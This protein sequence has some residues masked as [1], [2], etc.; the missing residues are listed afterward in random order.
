[1][2]AGPVTGI[3]VAARGGLGRLFGCRRARMWEPD[4]GR[5]PAW[6]QRWQSL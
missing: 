2:R 1:V 6:A 3:Q 5:P 4:H